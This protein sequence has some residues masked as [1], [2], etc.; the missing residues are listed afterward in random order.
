MAGSGIAVL[1]SN[2]RVVEPSTSRTGRFPA[3]P[4]RPAPTSS[5]G[6]GIAWTGPNAAAPVN[7]TTVAVAHHVERGG[8]EPRPAN[9]HPA[10]ADLVPSPWFQE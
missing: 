3:G 4:G 10:D 8:P 6:A 9:V 7:A 1:G 2:G 5:A